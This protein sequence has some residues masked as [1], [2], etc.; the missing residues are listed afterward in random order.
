MHHVT[1]ARFSASRRRALLRVYINYLHGG[2]VELPHACEVNRGAVA[3]AGYVCGSVTVHGFPI[4]LSLVLA[5]L[6]F[7]PLERQQQPTGLI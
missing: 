2:G 6:L 4:K 5:N 7:A 1:P 3:A